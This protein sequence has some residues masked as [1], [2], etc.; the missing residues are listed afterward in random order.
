MTSIDNYEKP[1]RIAA[2]FGN[3]MYKKQHLFQVLKI[4]YVLWF[5]MEIF[6]KNGYCDCVFHRQHPKGTTLT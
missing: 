1:K 4:T 2:N 3:Y 5:G 6:E